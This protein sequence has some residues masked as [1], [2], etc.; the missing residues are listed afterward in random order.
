MAAVAAEAF[1]EK[2]TRY[3]R[4]FSTLRVERTGF[5]AQWRDLADHVFPQ[6]PKFFG[7]TDK[8]NGSRRTQKI[9]DG[10]A[11]K[12]MQTLRAGL[13][14]G[15]T[16]PARPWFHLGI[17]DPELAK[18]PTVKAWLHDVT[19]RMYAVLQFSNLYNA[20]PLV[21]GDAATFGTAAVAM[22]D[23]PDDLFRFYPYPIGSYWLGVGANGLTNTFI[24]EYPST[25]GQL[26]EAFGGPNGERLEPGD[27]PDWSRFSTKVKAWYGL[28]DYEKTVEVCWYVL[29]NR[30]YQADALGPQR[31]PWSSCW[32]EKGTDA[33]TFLREKGFHEFPIFAPR[34][35]ANAEDTYG[36]ECPG[37][38][39]ISDVRQLQV[40]QKRTD[41]AIEKQLNPP[42]QA[43][44]ELRTQK[45][46]LIPSD[47]TYVSNFERGGAKPI[48][49]VKPDVGAMLLRVQAKQRDIN[50]AWF[51]DLFRMLSDIDEQRGAQPPTA[52]EI[53]ERHEEK[54]VILGPV[55]DSFGGELLKPLLNR[56]FY[57]MFRAGYIPPAPEELEGVELIPEFVS[58]LAQARKMSAIGIHAG[59]IQ[60]V[61]QAAA[62]VPDAI[63]AI[64]MYEY[65]RVQ[66]DA[67]GVVPTILRSKEQ[68]AAI[69]QSRAQQQQQAMAVEQAAKMGAATKAMGTTPMD[70]DTALTRMLQGVTG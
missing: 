5:E 4:L 67:Y 51:V 30:D 26:V 40:M 11:T 69:Q 8:N 14:A 45:V 59:F 66:G 34:W 43:S 63:D 3:E 41:Q 6:R 13:H 54:M 48:H 15:M 68:V 42:L 39:S 38:T 47:I 28:G 62:V 20:L 49:E 58:I 56:A 32:L 12:A 18:V 23:D 29:P 64:D 1:T 9:F 16:N 55:L 53:D 27:D 24:R 65:V 36:T 10:T 21:Y 46:S 25:V 60:T 50:E 31:F 70:G 17:G 37:M 7:V 19:Q 33:N 35:F 52:R 2:R 22:L 44:A 61:T 57:M